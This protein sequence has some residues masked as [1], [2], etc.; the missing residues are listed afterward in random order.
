MSKKSML[1]KLFSVL[2]FVD[3]FPKDSLT[4]GDGHIDGI[5]AHLYY[6]H[7]QIQKAR[8]LN[9]SAATTL[10]EPIL[11]VDHLIVK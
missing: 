8:S 2:D 9:Q 10:C 4:G 11:K 6:D 7:S 3:D 5:K 1:T